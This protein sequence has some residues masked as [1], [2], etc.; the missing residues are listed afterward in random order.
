MADK[1]RLSKYLNSQLKKT[2]DPYYK[3]ILETFIYAASASS[4]KKTHVDV[5]TSKGNPHGVPVGI[6]VSNLASKLRTTL[7][8]LLTLHKTSY[9]IQVSLMLSHENFY[10]QEYE[11][12]DNSG[13]DQIGQRILSHENYK[14]LSDAEKDEFVRITSVHTKHFTKEISEAITETFPRVV[15]EISKLLFRSGKVF[16][17]SQ[18]ESLVY[19][20]DG[21]FLEVCKDE[22]TQGEY[23]VGDDV[24]DNS[25]LV[26][27]FFDEFLLFGSISQKNEPTITSSKA[28]ESHKFTM[29]LRH[30]IGDIKKG[31]RSNEQD[32]NDQADDARDVLKRFLPDDVLDADEKDR[33]FI[34]DSNAESIYRKI[35]RKFC[36]SDNVGKL[37]MYALLYRAYNIMT[38]RK[39]SLE[40]SY[41]TLFDYVLVNNK[42]ISGYALDGIDVPKNG[43]ISYTGVSR[44]EFTD[45]LKEIVKKESA[46]PRAISAF[47]KIFG[48]KTLKSV[49]KALPYSFEALIFKE[50][51]DKILATCMEDYN[52][53]EAKAQKV[54]KAEEVRKIFNNKISLIPSDELFKTLPKNFQ[55]FYDRDNVENLNPGYAQKFALSFNTLFRKSNKSIN[56]D[57]NFLDDINVLSFVAN[58]N[59][60]SLGASAEDIKS[61]VS[62]PKTPG[63]PGSGSNSGSGSGQGSRRA[64]THVD[65]I[66]QPRDQGRGRSK[67]PQGKD[68]GRDRSKSPQEKQGRDRSK[69]P[70]GDRTPQ[71]KQ[72]RTVTPTRDHK[73]DDKSPK[74]PAVGS[75]RSDR[76]DDSQ[77]P[78]KRTLRNMGNRV[79]AGN[80]LAR[81]S[82]T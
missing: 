73:T 46:S 58:L 57:G 78:K 14:K 65:T 64:A 30:V 8:N 70:G 45:A 15:V 60:L 3:Y 21:E 74:S 51:G 77:S 62:S 6:T 34:T 68:Q 23:S 48:S 27:K 28:S 9:Y 16:T 75:D 5:Y 29:I 69:S 35:I 41:L 22:V 36:E 79:V 53:A 17:S 4:T 76:G 82:D 32:H 13:S 38:Y 49:R 2:Q 25:D 43:K 61:P 19:N 72:D 39:A 1:V 55:D 67:S 37:S 63:S 26:K 44:E 59:L 33:D 11:Y 10:V 71:G 66:L 54:T 42:K 52:V 56:V 24:F 80:R 20:Y 31:T 40:A 47:I 7:V 81:K 18:N 12:K 50:K